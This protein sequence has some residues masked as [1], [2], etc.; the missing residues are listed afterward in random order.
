[1]VRRGRGV[2]CV[3]A[4]VASLF[5]DDHGLRGAALL[6]GGAAEAGARAGHGLRFQREIVRLDR[7]CDGW[8][9]DDG[10]WSEEGRDVAGGCDGGVEIAGLSVTLRLGLVFGRLVQVRVRGV[11]TAGG[12]GA[13][14]AQVRVVGVARVGGG[15]GGGGR[16]SC[17]GG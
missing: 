15:R 8:R 1:M 13:Q 3:A 11:M 14:E 4:G 6:L 17:D 7:S 16:V 5:L 9:F 2:H 10:R 12:G